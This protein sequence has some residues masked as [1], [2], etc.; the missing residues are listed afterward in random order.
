MGLQ[1]HRSAHQGLRSPIHDEVNKFS[2]CIKVVKE[3]KSVFTEL[4]NLEKHP[5][6]IPA[7]WDSIADG[8][9]DVLGTCT[10]NPSKWDFL[11]KIELNNGEEVTECI[12]DIITV[13][14]EVKHLGNL[15]DDIKDGQIKDLAKSVEGLAKTCKNAEK[16][17]I[18]K[19]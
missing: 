10:G 19:L 2:G 9:Y 15:I 13:A 4:G 16:D 7:Q 3:N 14:G 11:K 1:T 8:L 6:Q 12:D 5:D 18:K 17:N